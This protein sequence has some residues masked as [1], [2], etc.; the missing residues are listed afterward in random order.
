MGEGTL[1]DLVKSCYYLVPVANIMMT[2][3]N[4]ERCPSRW[5]QL[6]QRLVGGQLLYSESMPKIRLDSGTIVYGSQVWWKVVEEKPR[7]NLA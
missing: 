2:P 1:T 3:D 4:P 6:F 7:P 5:Y